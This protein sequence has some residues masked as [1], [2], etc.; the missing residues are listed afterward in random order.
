MKALTKRSLDPMKPWFSAVPVGKNKLSGMMKEMC[1]EAGLAG[2][3]TNHSLLAFGSTAL[4]S[5]GVSEALFGTASHWTSLSGRARKYKRV[6]AEQELQVSSILSAPHDTPGKH[7]KHSMQQEC[8]PPTDESFP[9][10]LAGCS[11]SGCT[12]NFIINQ[13]LPPAPQPPP[14]T[15]PIEELKAID[16]DELFAF[17]MYHASSCQ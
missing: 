6:T 15:D 11:F 17:E 12:G 4:F 13:P 1:L 9:L 2:S 10:S 16:I 7:L 14:E 5:S 3:Y 8:G